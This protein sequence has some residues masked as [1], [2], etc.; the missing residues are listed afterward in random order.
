MQELLHGRLDYN[1]FVVV[2]CYVTCMNVKKKKS[3]RIMN[4]T[5]LTY[6]PRMYVLLHYSIHGMTYSDLVHIAS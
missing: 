6:K 2:N 5:K 4:S 1:C 3:S